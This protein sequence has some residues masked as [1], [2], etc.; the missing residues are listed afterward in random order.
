MGN[1]SDLEQCRSKLFFEAFSEGRTWFN[2]HYIYINSP[3]NDI[4]QFIPH[5][6]TNPRGSVFGEYR[7]DADNNTKIVGAILGLLTREYQYFEEMKRD[8][9]YIIVPDGEILRIAQLNGIYKTR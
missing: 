7:W 1:F 4:P 2:L 9:S 5:L 6:I 3:P 8:D